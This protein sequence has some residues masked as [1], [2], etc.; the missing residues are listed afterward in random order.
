MER[1]LNFIN[2]V[3][4]GYSTL[5]GKSWKKGM[6]NRLGIMFICTLTAKA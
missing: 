4:T 3:K 2:P 5:P 6:T 1:T